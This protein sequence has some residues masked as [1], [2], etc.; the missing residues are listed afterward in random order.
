MADDN[1]E[2]GEN[3]AHQQGPAASSGGPKLAVAIVLLILALAAAVYSGKKYLAPRGSGLAEQ[4]MSAEQLLQA[5][6]IPEPVGSEGA[7]LKIE[8]CVGHC[9]R[10]LMDCFV[11]CAKAW[12][13]KIRAE[14]YAYEST[15]GQELLQ[16]RGQELGSIFF[17]EENE[18][19]IGEGDEQRKVRF[20]GPPGIEYSIDDLV[21]ALREKLVEL[22]GELPEDFD[23]VV[24]VFGQWNAGQEN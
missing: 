22:Y 4:E 10:P 18:L 20:H 13:D 24:A 12:P 15:E 21:D 11:E 19:V 1:R 7:K 2:S 8:V 6:P 17:N 16:S 9:L 23:E 5:R 3:A 14:F